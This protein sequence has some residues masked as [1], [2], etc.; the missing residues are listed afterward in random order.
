MSKLTIKL[1]IETLLDAEGE[2]GDPDVEACGEL[3]DYLKEVGQG[4]PSLAALAD[5]IG[6]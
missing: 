4:D 6:K 2:H 1:L 3:V 5:A